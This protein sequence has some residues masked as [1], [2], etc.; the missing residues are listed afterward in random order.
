M[1]NTV[2]WPIASMYRIL[3]VCLSRV[4]YILAMDFPTVLYYILYIYIYIYIYI[5]LYVV[6]YNTM[7]VDI[8]IYI[9]HLTV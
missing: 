8:Y 4:V 2:G 3:M 5:Q 7:Q 1:Y 9:A 6:T